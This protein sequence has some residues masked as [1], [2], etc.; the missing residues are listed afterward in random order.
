MRYRLRTLLIVLALGPPVMWTGYRVR[1]STMSPE[2]ISSSSEFRSLIASGD[3]IIHLDVEWSHY[4]VANRP[5]LSR[6]RSKTLIDPRCRSVRWRRID[7]TN[8]Q[9][10]AIGQVLTDWLRGQKANPALVQNGYG[11]LLW[12]RDG[13]LV[14]WLSDPTVVKEDKL[15]ERTLIAFQHDSR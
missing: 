9:D 14:D 2:I 8:Q 3:A 1:V 13:Q 4:A 6:L 11:S 12:I 7:C 15:F 5:L 10:T